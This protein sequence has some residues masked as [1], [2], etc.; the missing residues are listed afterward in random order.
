M[1]LDHARTSWWALCLIF[2]IPIAFWVAYPYVIESRFRIDSKGYEESGKFG[3]TYGA[4][5]ALFSALAFAGVLYSILR[6]H[7]ERQWRAKL[8]AFDALL[9]SLKSQYDAA[10]ATGAKPTVIGDLAAKLLFYSEELAEFLTGKPSGPLLTD[11][12]I[13]EAFSKI[14]WFAGDDIKREVAQMRSHLGRW[15]IVSPDDLD[16]LI[17]RNDIKTIIEEVYTRMLGRPKES[18]FDPAAL[19]VWGGMLFRQGTDKHTVDQFEANIRASEEYKE[20]QRRIGK[21]YL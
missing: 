15:R 20:R 18:P 12:H 10:I 9:N 5:S 13:V 6:D 3:D 2:V 1:K 4:L 16:A 21:R 17:A 14:P 19:A 7:K 11:A 8:D